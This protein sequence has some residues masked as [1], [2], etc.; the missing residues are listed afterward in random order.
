MIG[1]ELA[2]YFENPARDALGYEHVG[3]CLRFGR[4]GAELFFDEKDRAFRKI[5]PQTVA[6]DYLEIVRVSYQD[7]WFRPKVLVF[8]TSSPAKLTDFP[9]AAVGRVELVVAPGSRAAAAKAPA[10]VEFKRSEAQLARSAE[11]IE[12]RLGKYE[13]GL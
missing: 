5:P 10:L 13:S 7:R 6:F 4:D 1:E 8:E 9:G 12:S 3:G 11:Q 2:I